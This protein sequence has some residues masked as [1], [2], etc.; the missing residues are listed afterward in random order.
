MRWKFKTSQ[1]HLDK[2]LEEAMVDCYAEYEAFIGV[3]TTLDG[4]L[5]FP[6]EAEALG[7]TVEVK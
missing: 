3:V 2:L 7:E 5:P 4:K 1:K 6:F